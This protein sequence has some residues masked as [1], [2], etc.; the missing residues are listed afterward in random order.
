M[1]MYT[2]NPTNCM[3]DGD[4]DENSNYF[5]YYRQGRDY[6]FRKMYK[7]SVI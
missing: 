4:D 6:Y 7:V 1:S 3:Y 5:E 2:W